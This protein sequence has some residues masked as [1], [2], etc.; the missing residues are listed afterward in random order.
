MAIVKTQTNIVD[1][2]YIH[3]RTRR[4]LKESLDE[5]ASANKKSVGLVTVE[6]LEKGLRE[7]LEK[8]GGT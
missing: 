3:I 1:P 5:Y 6:L 8:G 4:A 7:V 2:A